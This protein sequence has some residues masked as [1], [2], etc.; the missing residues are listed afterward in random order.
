[1][2]HHILERKG[3]GGGKGEGGGGK[4]GRGWGEGGKGDGVLMHAFFL[5]KCEPCIS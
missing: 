3:G 5:R 1:M 2:I 4:G